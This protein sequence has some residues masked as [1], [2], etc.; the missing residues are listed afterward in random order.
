MSFNRPAGALAKGRPFR[1][2]ARRDYLSPRKAVNELFRE[3]IA[4]S[5]FFV[6]PALAYGLV[7]SRLPAIKA[8]AMLNDAQIAALLL[9]LGVATLLGLLLAG[10]AIDR[11]GA[12]PLTSAAI[13]VFLLAFVLAC[14]PRGYWW[15]FACFAVG[16]VAVG[17]C[18]VGMNAL[19]IE[20]ERRRGVHCLAF[21]HAICGLGGV[22][23]SVS[24]SLCAALALS[25]FQ[26][27]LVVFAAFYCLKPLAAKFVAD[28]APAQSAKKTE[29]FSLPLI[30]IIFGVANLLC[31]IVE[32]S[33]GSWGALLL[34]S[35][36]GASREEAALV[37]AAFTGSMTVCRLFADKARAKIADYTIA[38]CG[39]LLGA[40]G[41][42]TVLLSPWPA[43]CLAGYALMGFGLAPVAPLLF[44]R[45]GAL[46]GV[47]A[48]KAS[49]VISLFS[50]A[51]LLLFPPCLGFLSRDFGLNGALWSV[52]FAICLM[53]VACL[54][55][56]NKP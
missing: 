42:I 39:G 55:L 1:I 17:L 13:P 31:H 20:L 46:P 28:S 35:V 14:S 10:F 36:K 27:A 52:V 54:P 47:G 53:L 9:A 21:L 32:G 7:M 8:A 6:A 4:C 49:A 45:A 22:A 33:A 2:L 23:G 48:G 18:D 37:F 11:F 3:K 38:L 34:T 19:G 43:L 25:P 40:A 50:Y 15:T 51:G 29:P 26:N 41:M 5:W 30:L 44:S 24:G 12:K 56:R 16:G